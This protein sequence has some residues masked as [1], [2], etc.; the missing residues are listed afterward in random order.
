MEVRILGGLLVERVGG[1]RE[2]LVGRVGGSR[3]FLVGRV[4]GVRGFLVGRVGGLGRGGI[5]VTLL[6]VDDVCAES[7]EDASASL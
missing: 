2:L 5:L 7:A 1:L 3:G 6:M 4:G